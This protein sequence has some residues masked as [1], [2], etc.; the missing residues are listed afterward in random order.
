MITFPF[1]QR[2]HCGEGE[3]V[4]LLLL[5]LVS[6]ENHP[7]LCSLGLIQL[8]QSWEKILLL[9]LKRNCHLFYILYTK[10]L[11]LLSFLSSKPFFLFK[12]CSHPFYVLLGFLLEF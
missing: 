10:S 7:A 3:A 11:G 6:L 5:Y 12:L 8:L 1:L 9:L 2:I 4:L